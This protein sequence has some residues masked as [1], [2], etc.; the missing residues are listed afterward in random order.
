[1]NK[2]CTIC[3]KEKPIENFSWKNKAQNKRASECKV[4]HKKMRRLYYEKNKS[5]EVQQAK[6]RRNEIKKWIRQRVDGFSC[7]MCGERHISTL[8][9]YSEEIDEKDIDLTKVHTL[10][11]NMKRITKHIFDKKIVCS[12]CYRKHRWGEAT[13]SGLWTNTSDLK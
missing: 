4:C 6:K 12:N 7:S 8:I 11:W 9:L 13:S 2:Q 10:G 3:E 5:K 1:M